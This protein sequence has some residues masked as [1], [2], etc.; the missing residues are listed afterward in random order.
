MTNLEEQY[1]LGNDQYPNMLKKGTDALNSHKWDDAW[2][3]HMNNKHIYLL[4]ESGSV[5]G[6][7]SNTADL[8]ISP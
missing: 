4:A 1:A 6:P 8:R 7:S 5:A 2:S 3:N